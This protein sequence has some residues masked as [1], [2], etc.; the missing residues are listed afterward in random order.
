MPN[1]YPDPPREFSRGW[2]SSLVRC[3]EERDRAVPDPATFGTSDIIDLRARNAPLNGTDNDAGALLDALSL[4]DASG[5]GSVLIPSGRTCYINSTVVVPANCAVI[6]SR[7][8]PVGHI[9]PSA[10]MGFRPRVVLGPAGKLVL[11]NSSGLIGLTI[12]R[13]DL[14]WY[15]ASSTLSDWT[16]TA[17]EIADLTTDSIVEDCTI[18]GFAYGIRSALAATNV[19]RVRLARLNMDNINCVLLEN[20]YDVTYLDQIHCWPF[21]TVASEPESNNVHIKRSGAGIRLLGSHDWTKVTDCFTF[22][23]AYG[24]YASGADSVTFLSCGNDHPAAAPDGSFGFLI[25]GDSFECRIIGGQV[26]GKT[27]GI[28]LNSSSVNGSLIVSATNVWESKGNAVVNERGR[29]V[30]D[31][32]SLRNTDGAGTG[33]A[34]R[35]TSTETRI[36]NGEITGFS[37]GI[38]AES[39]SVRVFHHNVDFSGTTTGVVNPFKPTIASAAT[40]APDG[41]CIFYEVTGT[42]NI[43]SIGNAAAYAGRMLALKFTGTLTVTDGGNLKLGGDFSATAD[44]VLTLLSDG[45]N[46]YQVGSSAN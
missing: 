24:M 9:N 20:S 5:G 14:A 33:V 15:G 30:M 17:V 12:M 3:L 18:L 25:D 8:G 31:G 45:T 21:V 34:A 13:H 35:D 19:S 37:V 43:T 11:N 10:I 46:W 16:G 42:T 2:A 41:E 36:A 6:G 1:R 39:S 38:S 23:Y 7:R 22:G 44:D 4:A 26:A 27:N 29:L 40:I 32:F 28:Y